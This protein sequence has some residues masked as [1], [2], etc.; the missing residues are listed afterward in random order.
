MNKSEEEES[1]AIPVAIR[2]SLFCAIGSNGSHFCLWRTEAAAVVADEVEEAVTTADCG[3]HA[4]RHQCIHQG[5]QRRG[6]SDRGGRQG[7]HRIKRDRRKAACGIRA[8]A[9]MGCRPEQHFNG[10]SATWLKWPVLPHSPLLQQTPYF[11][12]AMAAKGKA[13]AQ[14]DALRADPTTNPADAATAAQGVLEATGLLRTMEANALAADPTML[15]Q[16]GKAGG[17]QCQGQRY[18]PGV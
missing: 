12:A 16:Q 7:Y 6:G 2:D 1:N 17:R 5:P 9:G 18:A 10:T 8:D 4:P 13:E 14:R 15:P 3:D 11:A